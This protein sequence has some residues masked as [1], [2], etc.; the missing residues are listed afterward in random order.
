[1]T[2]LSVWP[3]KLSY[4]WV[5]ITPIRNQSP[6]QNINLLQYHI[7]YFKFSLL[8]MYGLTQSYWNKNNH[9]YTEQ[10]HII[11]KQYCLPHEAEI[12]L[13]PYYVAHLD[14]TE[15]LLL[16]HLWWVIFGPYDLNKLLQEIFLCHLQVESLATVLHT[17]FQHLWA[18]TQ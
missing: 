5:R 1:M 15:N 6:L 4:A 17:G 18:K 2:K 9:P 16:H 3:Q 8:L 13:F 7:I 11:N 14:E 10:W 12:N